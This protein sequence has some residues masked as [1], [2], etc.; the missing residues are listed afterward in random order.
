MTTPDKDKGKKRKQKQK[1]K[2]KTN[3]IGD[4]KDNSLRI[5]GVIHWKN[6]MTVNLHPFKQQSIKNLK[7]KR[8]KKRK[9]HYKVLVGSMNV[10]YQTL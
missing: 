6:I 7:F 10:F 2:K 3:L 1:N 9:S 4:K 8:I 5:K